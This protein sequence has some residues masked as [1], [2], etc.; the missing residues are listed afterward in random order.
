MICSVLTAVSIFSGVCSD[1]VP[2]ALAGKPPSFNVEL[3]Q[4]IINNHRAG[5]G[6]APLAIDERLMAAAKAHSADLSRRGSVTHRGSDGSYPKDRARRYGY[7]PRLASENVA[8]GYHNTGD[9]IKGWKGSRGHNENLLR[10]GAKHMGMALV[11]KP[12]VG[13]ETYWTLVI[14]TPR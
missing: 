10:R 9:V 7:K 2:Q 1:A 5:H 4:Q 6:L 13:K 11:Y 8:A 12:N 14:G 3:A